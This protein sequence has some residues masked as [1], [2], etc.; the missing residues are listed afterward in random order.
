MD[1][2]VRK[3]LDFAIGIDE[4]TDH[5]VVGQGTIRVVGPV[6]SREG[7]FRLVKHLSDFLAVPLETVVDPY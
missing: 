5:I 4:V 6:I 1:S 3:T 7:H 2:E